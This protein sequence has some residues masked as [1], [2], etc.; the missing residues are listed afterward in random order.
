MWPAA[1]FNWLHPH[2]HGIAK[3]QV[4]SGMAGM[5]VMDC[6]HY[7]D[8]NGNPIDWLS[9]RDILLKDIR[10]VQP[11]IAGPWLNFADQALDFCGN[12]KFGRSNIGSCPLGGP[13][14][15]G[16]VYPSMTLATAG[17]TDHRELWRIQMRRPLSASA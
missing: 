8:E 6:A 14:I 16:A 15:A 12:S 17:L 2:V 4:A 13:D 10:I 3:A 5:I 7:T 11:D 1:G 9:E